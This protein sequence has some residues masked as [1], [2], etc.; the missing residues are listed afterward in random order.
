ML[1]TILYIYILCIQLPPHSLPIFSVPS[2]SEFIDRMCVRGVPLPRTAMAISR[3]PPR[4][5]RF[6]S[7]NATVLI[8]SCYVRVV[9]FPGVRIF[10]GG[11]PDSGVRKHGTILL[12][13]EI[14]KQI[15]I[16]ENG[17]RG[18]KKHTPKQVD[19][20]WGSNYKINGLRSQLAHPVYDIMTRYALYDLYNID[21]LQNFIPV[22]FT[23]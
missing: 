13:Q 8:I 3:S 16:N 2:A 19:P 11:G 1:Y 22:Y 23:S 4:R 17:K 12:A 10:V 6:V 5:L 15:W 20:L 9:K 7:G 14:S 21:W 18:E